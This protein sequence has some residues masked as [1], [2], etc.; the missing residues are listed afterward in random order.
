M[1]AEESFRDPGEAMFTLMGGFVEGAGDYQKRA[2]A[3]FEEHPPVAESPDSEHSSGET[4][5]R[6]AA[7]Y[8]KTASELN[9]LAIQFQRNEA[10]AINPYLEDLSDE[11]VDA[12]IQERD[13]GIER[14]AE[15]R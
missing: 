4:Y 11:Q 6:M 15:G 14:L 13:A 7:L 9:D 2:A 5:Q 1:K 3:W 8:E 10:R 12:F